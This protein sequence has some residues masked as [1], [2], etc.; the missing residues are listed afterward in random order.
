[1]KNRKNFGFN[2]FYR[3]QPPRN[4]LCTI[5]IKLGAYNIKS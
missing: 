1:M 4:Q 5:T 2:L 3:T